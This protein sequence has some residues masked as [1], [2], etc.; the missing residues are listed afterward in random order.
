MSKVQ[1]PSDLHFVSSLGP[2]CG[3]LMQTSIKKSGLKTQL[4]SGDKNWKKNLNLK[5][6][7][8]GYWF[9]LAIDFIKIRRNVY[10]NGYQFASTT[11]IANW[12]IQ[13]KN[14]TFN[15]RFLNITVPPLNEFF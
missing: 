12:T 10:L 5:Q 3:H 8:L 1:I 13:M 15:R 14:L 6:T 4:S 7:E 9:F 2:E 11:V